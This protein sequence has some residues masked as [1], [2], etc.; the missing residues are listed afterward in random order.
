MAK[1]FKIGKPAG[2]CTH[3][4]EEIAPGEEVM[5]LARMTGEEI[6]R[7]DYSLAA[8]GEIDT[9]A[10][11]ADPDVLGIWRTRRP[12]PEEKKKLLI[13]DNLILQFFERL[14]GTDD[15]NRLNFRYVLCL[16]L[17]RKRLLSY[18]GMER[19]EDGTEVWQMRR[20]GEGSMHEV[21]DPKLDEDKIA[22]VS[23]QL[24]DIMQE[25]FAEEP[26][27]EADETDEAGE[28]SENSADGEDESVEAEEATDAKDEQ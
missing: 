8:W 2:I 11:S 23:Q 22:T 1:D 10:L 28:M 6:L 19:R 25:D 4:G 16:I 15:P 14:T 12:Q 3:S 24:G 26:P 21:I 7:E 13:D 20:R 17:M 9:A 27:E 5:A 18:E